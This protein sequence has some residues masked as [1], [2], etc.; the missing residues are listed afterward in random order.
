MIAFVK[1]SMSFGFVRGRKH[2]GTE[3]TEKL[4]HRFP[5][6]S[7]APKL[8]EDSG[9]DI[10]ALRGGGVRWSDSDTSA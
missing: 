8:L 5:F 10:I 7:V 2:R 1:S 4:G 6:R 9:C 3:D